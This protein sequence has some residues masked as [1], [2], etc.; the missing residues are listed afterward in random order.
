MMENLRSMPDQ[1]KYQRANEMVRLYQKHVLPFVEQHLGYAEMHNLR[2]IWQ[3]GITSIQE[4]DSEHDKYEKAYSNW[5]W[6]ANCSHNALADKLSSQEILEYKRLLLHLYEQLLDTSN[7]SILRL[8]RAHRAL[9]KSLLYDMQWLTP[10]ELTSCSAT[11]VTCVVHECKILQVS[12][13]IRVCRVDCRNVGTAYAR[14]IYHLKRVTVLSN[15]GCTI[16]LT[17][18]EP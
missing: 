18:L 7:L 11:K 5:I 16:T 15:H 8:I 1:E 9:A 2:S 14:S 12:G 6:L 3:A 4:H 10:L 13:A 17:P